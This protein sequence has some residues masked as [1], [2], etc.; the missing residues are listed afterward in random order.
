ML[1]L[2]IRH[3][4]TYAERDRVMAIYAPL[5]LLTL[6]VAWLAL[7]LLG[8]AAMFQVM[9]AV[10]IVMAIVFAMGTARQPSRA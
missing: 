3:L 1:E 6:P 4:P 2:W 8:Y 9:A 10:A 5:G 7:V